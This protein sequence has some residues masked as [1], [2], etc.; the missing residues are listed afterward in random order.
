LTIGQLIR[1]Y[2]LAKGLSQEQCAT[3]LG[4]THRSNYYKLE[5]GKLEWK[6]RDFI[7]L[8]ELLEEAPEQLIKEWR[9]Q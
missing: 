9:Q 3:Y 8:A 1:R 5:S 7:K 6:L 2:R 4:F